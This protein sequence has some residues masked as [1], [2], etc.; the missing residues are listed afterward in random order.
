MNKTSILSIGLLI[1]FFLP[2]FD[3]NLF[4]ISG[5]EIPTSFEKLSNLNNMFGNENK[6]L[7]NTTKF[8]YILYLIP[9][10]SLINLFKEFSKAKRAY[11]FNEFLV[12]LIAII[13]LFFVAKGYK[14]DFNSLFGIGFYVTLLISVLGLY[15]CISL[16]VKESEFENENESENRIFEQ[17]QENKTIILS[18]ISLIVLFFGGYLYLNSNKKLEEKIIGVWNFPNEMV[19]EFKQDK[20]I[21]VSGLEND[22][23]LDG[24]YDVS[25]NE[26]ELSL[27]IPTNNSNNRYA[28][29]LIKDVKSNE[30]KLKAKERNKRDE[31]EFTITKQ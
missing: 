8:S 21:I 29:F 23:Q 4:T 31:P 22:E 15:Y 3:L 1:A 11:I 10:L 27:Q 5:F 12:G 13:Y 2:W 20:K 19:I 16:K 6:T 7:S 28:T 17:I 26:Q 14:K 25:I 30:I 24:I 18:F 9:F